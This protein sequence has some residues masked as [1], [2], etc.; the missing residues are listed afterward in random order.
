V[1]LQTIA[2]VAWAQT[3]GIEKVEV[4]IDEGDWQEA[5]LADELA[6][7]TW[8]QWRLRWEVTSGRHTIT[9]RATDGTGTTQTEKRARPMPDGA[10]GWHQIVVMGE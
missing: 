1:G 9:V 7:T 10:T 3:R 5:E 2:G 6:N 4:S 8:R